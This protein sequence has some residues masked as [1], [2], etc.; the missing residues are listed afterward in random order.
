[1]PKQTTAVEWL[2]EQLNNLRPHQYCSIETIREW[3]YHAK[4]LEKGQIIDAY[5]QADKDSNGKSFGHGEQYYT[6]KFS[7]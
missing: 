2:I 7:K 4:G 3:C 1:M 6:E 5:N